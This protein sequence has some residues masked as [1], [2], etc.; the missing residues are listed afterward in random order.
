MSQERNYIPLDGGAQVPPNSVF[1]QPN[2]PGYGMPG[3]PN[4]QGMPPMFGGPAPG[5]LPFPAPG[6]IPFP[7][8]GGLPFP[9]PGAF[10]QPMFFQGNQGF[11][12]AAPY[13]PMSS[14]PGPYNQ[15]FND[16]PNGSI[17]YGL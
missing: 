8:P 14:Q 5:G 10:M 3:T 12:T 4:M 16:N 15:G 7:A 13:A 6:G 11:G 9:P 1:G 17:N 2:P